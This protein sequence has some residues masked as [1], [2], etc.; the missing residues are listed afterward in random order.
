MNERIR[1]PEIRV[2]GSD[3]AQLGVMS[4]QEAMR[5]AMDEGLDLVEISP[6]AK[7]PV[8]KIMDYGK[9]KYEQQKKDQENKKKQVKVSVK[10]IKMRPNTDQHDIEFKMNHVRRF[11]ADKDKAKLTIQFR[12]RE[13]V[14]MDRAKEML[15]KIVTDL[16]DVAVAEAPPKLEGRTLSVILGPK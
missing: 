9:Y 7:P 11:I 5:L 3:G 14:H 12:G 16:A 2:I 13:I 4:P 15:N 1:V 10:E 8:C 6:T